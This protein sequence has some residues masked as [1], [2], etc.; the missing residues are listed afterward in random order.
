MTEKKS[1]RREVLEGAAKGVVAG[2]G[3]GGVGVGAHKVSENLTNLARA[4]VTLEDS[5]Q[6]PNNVQIGT[7]R[8]HS[9]AES[10]VEPSISSVDKIISEKNSRNV[11]LDDSHEEGV[12]PEYVEFRR[13]KEAFYQQE[14][15]VLAAV[16]SY[17]AG[18][19]K[20]G[21]DCIV[22]YLDES[23]ITSI[24]TSFFLNVSY[25]DKS[26]AQIRLHE[27]GDGSTYES[28]GNVD[29]FIYANTLDSDHS[30]V[31]DVS[32]REVKEILTEVLHR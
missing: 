16:D 2:L 20:G 21:V 5:Q 8:V 3:L 9:S 10:T 18:L 30:M 11:N 1:T 26:V 23:H 17:L 22:K 29:I 32:P 6:S 25:K 13:R 15:S 14:K 27:S 31:K 7:R 28:N 19:S 24:H 4:G 12:A